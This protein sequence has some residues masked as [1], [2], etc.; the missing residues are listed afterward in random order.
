M[1]LGVAAESGTATNLTPRPSW[2]K[3]RALNH[4][5]GWHLLPAAEIEILNPAYCAESNR[6]RVRG[7]AGPPGR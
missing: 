6:I 2:A 3:M 7:C 4:P 1:I 5:G